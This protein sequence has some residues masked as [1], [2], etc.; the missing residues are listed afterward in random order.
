VRRSPAGDGIPLLVRAIRLSIEAVDRARGCGRTLG[1]SRIWIF[2]TVTLRWRCRASLRACPVARQALGEFG[3]TIHLRVEHSGETQ[4]ISAA[5]YTYT[6]V[7]GGDGPALRLVLVAVVIAL[8]ALVFRNV[9]RRAGIASTGRVMLIVDVEKRLGQFTV[10]ARFRDRETGSPR[11]S[12]LRVPAD[13]H[14]R[15]DCRP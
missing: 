11:C 9:C 15:H 13:Q 12:A 2:A 14:H 3:A 4:T 5:I 6:Q 7:P 10:S 1:A 8:A